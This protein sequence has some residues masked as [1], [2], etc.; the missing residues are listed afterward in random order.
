[1]VL[2]TGDDVRSS[3]EVNVIEGAVM[4]PHDS[5]LRVRLNDTLNGRRMTRTSVDKFKC[6]VNQRTNCQ[7]SHTATLQT[8]PKPLHVLASVS[9]LAPVIKI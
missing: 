1:M 5:G 3:R 7:Q 4:I 6:N 8:M 2:L 9:E